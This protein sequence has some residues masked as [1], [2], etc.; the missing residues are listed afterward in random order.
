M[1]AL[2]DAA[3]DFSLTTPAGETLTLANLRLGKKATLVN[4][5]FLA[6]PPCREEFRLFQRLYVD[7][8]DRGFAIVA[9][10]NKDDAAEIRSYVRKAGI[11]FP[12]VIGDR[13]SPGVVGN[14]R[15]ETYPSTYLLNSEGK[16][17]YKSVGIDEAGLR[18]ALSALGLDR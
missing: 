16:I 1:L 8:K 18:R 3:P 17:V 11:T 10:N 12:M 15:I 14:Y 7:L 5:W 13:E 9:I 2:G 4:F 6:C